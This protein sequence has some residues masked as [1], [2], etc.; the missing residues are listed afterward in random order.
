MPPDQSAHG[1]MSIP[2]HFSVDETVARIKQA[3]DSGGIKI[4]AIVDHSGEA[5]RV[6]LHMP[7]T[8]LIIFGNPKA[9]TPLMIAAPSVAIDLPLKLLVCEDA[10]GKTWVSY[11]SPEFLSARHD[12]PSDLVQTLAGTGV[13]A[14]KAATPQNGA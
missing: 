3:L 4:F 9:G 5:E 11:N 10:A 14:K 12:V 7:N 13:I 6:G 8:K 1:I 2:S